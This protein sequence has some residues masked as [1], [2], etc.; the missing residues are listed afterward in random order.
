MSISSAI[1]QPLLFAVRFL[2]N[3]FTFGGAQADVSMIENSN[4]D[5]Y[6]PGLS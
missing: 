2:G 6:P 4:N 3:A 5:L 1:V